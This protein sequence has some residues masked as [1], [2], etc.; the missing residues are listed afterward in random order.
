[1]SSKIEE[2]IRNVDM[3][4]WQ[5]YR[6]EED[7]IEFC[8]KHWWKLKEK[9]RLGK[10]QT[11]GQESNIVE[12]IIKG[13]DMAAWQ[14]DTWEEDNIELCEKNWWKLNDKK[15]SEAVFLVMCNPSMNEL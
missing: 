5:E 4:A 2:V 13:V 9:K 1:M 8:E 12:E 6:R 15:S 3:A 10:A 7:N 11:L 14:E